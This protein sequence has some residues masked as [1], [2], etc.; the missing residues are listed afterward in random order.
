MLLLIL[1]DVLP[2]IIL[3]WFSVRLLSLNGATICRL[4][5]FDVPVEALLSFVFFVV[6]S[7]P[8]LWFVSLFDPAEADDSVCCDVLLSCSLSVPDVDRVFQKG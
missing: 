7:D 6:E 1:L 8:E 4:T 5:W 2:S 3:R